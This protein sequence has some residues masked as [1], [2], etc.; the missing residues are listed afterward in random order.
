MIQDND[1]Q[2]LDKTLDS[3]RRAHDI[4]F[5]RSLKLELLTIS[6]DEIADINSTM[7]AKV[8]WQQLSVDTG[9]TGN[10]LHNIPP[11]THIK[12]DFAYYVAEGSFVGKSRIDS[13]PIVIIERIL[14]K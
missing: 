4:D 6:P 1:E 7:Y 11:H 3:V 8:T 2:V 9:L 14:K 10:K 5:L 13:R 12:L